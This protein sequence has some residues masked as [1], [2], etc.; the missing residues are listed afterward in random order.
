MPDELT[1]NVRKTDHLAWRALRKFVKQPGEALLLCR[2]AW[3]VSVLSVAARFC[4]L[5]QALA[6]VAGRETTS[7]RSDRERTERGSDRADLP[8]RLARSID[9]LLSANFFV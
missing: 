6:L 5:P 9:L 7:T 1:T 2:M 4:S 8:E 3:W